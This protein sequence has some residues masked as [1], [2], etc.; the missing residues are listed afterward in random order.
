MNHRLFS[1]HSSVI[2]PQRYLNL[3]KSQFSAVIALPALYNFLIIRSWLP[4]LL[5]AVSKEIHSPWHDTL[6]CFFRRDV[7]V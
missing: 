5:H 4:F 3:E 1:A 6:S 7:E 2:N